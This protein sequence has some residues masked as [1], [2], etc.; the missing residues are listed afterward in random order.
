MEGMTNASFTMA[1]EIIRTINEDRRAML[2]LYRQV[3]QNDVDSIK[4]MVDCAI[5]VYVQIHNKV[6]IVN[7]EFYNKLKELKEKCI[8]ISRQDVYK[9][10][11]KQQYETL[12]TLTKLV[13]NLQE[14]FGII[15]I[16]VKVRIK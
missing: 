6:K 5:L 3:L 14:A 13:E 12:D 1:D 10:S 11:N 8:N 7:E 4:P 2:M 15:G 16:D 9:M